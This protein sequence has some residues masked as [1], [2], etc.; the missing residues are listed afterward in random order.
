MENLFLII[1][2]I[3][4]L[5]GLVFMWISRPARVISKINYFGIITENKPFYGIKKLEKRLNLLII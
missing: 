1:I 2:N 5:L 4:W 3:S